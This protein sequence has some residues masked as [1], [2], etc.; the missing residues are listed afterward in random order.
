M[1]YKNH[2]IMD[3]LISHSK[4]VI[5]NDFTLKSKLFNVSITDLRKKLIDC[6]ALHCN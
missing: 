1:R 6:V 3:L 5:S 2:K 4:L